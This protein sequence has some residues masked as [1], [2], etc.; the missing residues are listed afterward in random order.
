MMCL[1]SDVTFFGMLRAFLSTFFA[2]SLAR[3]AVRMCA[4]MLGT[5]TGACPANVGA[6]GAKISVMVRFPRKR[7]HRCGTDVRTVQ[8]DQR[9][10]R[11]AFTN[12]SCSACLARVDCFFACFNASLHISCFICRHY[13]LLNRID[14]Y[15]AAR[16]TMPRHVK[17]NPILNLRLVPHSEVMRIFERFYP[18]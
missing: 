11:A 8:V 6:Q 3:G 13:S 14:E 16:H 15:D 9:A 18:L 5:H 1:D 7:I 12:I 10:V 4:G 2:R 17:A